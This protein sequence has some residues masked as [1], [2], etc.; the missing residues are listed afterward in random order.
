M[1]N[2]FYDCYN[3]LS[4]VYSSAAYLKQAL[5]DTFIEELNRSNITKIC[6]GVLDKDIQ[7]EYY[8]SILCVKRPKTSIRII[9]KISMYC[10]KYL[11]T[12]NYAVVDNA[13]ELVKKLGKGGTSGFVNAFLR[14]FISHEI[15]LPH[16]EIERL[17]VQYSYPVFAVKKLIKDYGIDIAVSLMSADT[18]RTCVRFDKGENSEEYLKNL[19]L[20]SFETP[21]KN[22]YFIENFKRNEDYDKGVYTFQSIGSIAICDMVESG[23]NLLD[24]CAAPGG[25]SVYLADKFKAVTSCDIHEHRVKLIEEYARRMRK[26]NISAIQCDSSIFNKDFFGK[27]DSVLADVPCSGFGVIKDNPDIKLFRR[28]EDIYSLSKLQYKIL[29]NVSNYV[30]SGGYLYYSTCSVFNEENV[31]NCKKFLKEHSDFEYVDCESPLRNV[32]REVGIQFLPDISYGAGF[33]FC[34][35]RRK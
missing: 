2:T 3:V 35:F 19:K 33:Y 6:Y 5:N 14:K 4:K 24:V 1:I 10:I 11:S 17:S 7:F 25:K 22:A 18:E 15:D 8:I 27:F 32:K 12:A 34:K 21:F 30:K 29:Q 9:L 23:E 26:E 20:S 13:V 31:D 28:E 16:G